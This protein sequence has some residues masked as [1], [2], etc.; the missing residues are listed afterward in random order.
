[1]RNCD[2]VAYRQNLSIGGKQYSFWIFSK[3]SVMMIR[4]I[5]RLVVD[6][7]YWN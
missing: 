2:S 3:V 4:N 6:C 1:M 7:H 5:K